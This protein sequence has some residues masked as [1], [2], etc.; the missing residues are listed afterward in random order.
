M[1]YLRKL[2][3]EIQIQIYNTAFKLNYDIVMRELLEIE[4]ISTNKLSMR[5]NKKN[6]KFVKYFLESWDISKEE[7]IRRTFTNLYSDILRVY[8]QQKQLSITISK[9][10]NNMTKIIKTKV[11]FDQPNNKK[12]RK[13]YV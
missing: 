8:N 1:D 10:D 13:I 3:N 7:I 4:Y 5:A 9:S 11:P 12:Q 2:P 6:E